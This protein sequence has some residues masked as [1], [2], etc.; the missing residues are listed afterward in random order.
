MLQ[1]LR[2]VR[3]VPGDHFRRWFSDENLEIVV[4]YD[5]AG[6]IFGFQICYDPR[7]QP[8]ALTWTQKRGFSHAEIDAGE[9]KP[10]SNRTP[11][12]NPS[13]D[14]DAAK[15]SE[16]FLATAGGLPQRER[17]FIEGKLAESAAAK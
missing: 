14:Y 1:E 15:L 13:H 9:D 10:T 6:A 4:W 2:N 3:Q 5:E 11:L 17:I 7:E 12:L 16:A 8:R